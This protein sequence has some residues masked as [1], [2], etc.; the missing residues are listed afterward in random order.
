[1]RRQWLV[2][3]L[4]LVPLGLI[5]GSG[6]TFALVNGSNSNRLQIERVEGILDGQIA[7]VEVVIPKRPGPWGGV[8]GMTSQQPLPYSIDLRQPGQVEWGFALIGQGIFQ[9]EKPGTYTFTYGIRPWNESEQWVHFDLVQAVAF[10]HSLIDAKG[11]VDRSELLG[12]VAYAYSRDSR[13]TMTFEVPEA[14]TYRVGYGPAIGTA[15]TLE[16]LADA[17][18]FKTLKENHKIRL[19][20]RIDG[21]GTVTWLDAEAPGNLAVVMS[22]T[23]THVYQLNRLPVYATR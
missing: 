5:A 14:G 8:L 10:P 1:M 23:T 6:I 12:H 4:L 15:A 21:P 9:V 3:S 20:L 13:L 2:M 22:S 19:N 18:N 16:E 17:S 7:N 11:V